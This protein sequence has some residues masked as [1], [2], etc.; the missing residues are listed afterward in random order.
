VRARA[1]FSILLI[2]IFESFFSNFPS[3]RWGD[4]WGDILGVIWGDIWGV[5]WG[6]ITICMVRFNGH[7]LYI[8]I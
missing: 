5:I 3:K 8:A 4:I 7:F 2:K 1:R 6:M